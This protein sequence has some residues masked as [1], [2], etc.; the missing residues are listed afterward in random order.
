MSDSALNKSQLVDE[1]YAKVDG[2]TK[3][4]AGEMLDTLLDTVIASV[5]DGRDVAL[6]GF[7]KFTR[8]ERA[9]RAARNPQTGATIRLPAA[10]APGF[11][12]GKAFKVA[13]NR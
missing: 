6:S 11:R 12:A 2:I 9:A 13:V 3:K 7:G 4:Q 8:V 10:K 1:I 5:A